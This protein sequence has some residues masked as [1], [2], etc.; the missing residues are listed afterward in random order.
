MLVLGI[1]PGIAITGFGL[2]T[3]NQVGDPEMVDFGVIDSTA[4]STTSSRLVFLYDHLMELLSKYQPTHCAIEKLFFQKN[5]KT[6]MAVGEARGVIQL[7]L[8]QAHLEIMEY[9]P[10]SVK[11]AVTSY[12]S[13]SK[14]QVQE[15]VKILLNLDAIPTPDDAADA[16]AV[17]LCHIG[18]IRLQESLPDEQT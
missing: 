17:A 15:M 4:V 16:L 12:G 8:A 10:N 6:V 2:V 3:V 7:C 11:Q 9:S 13:A 1:D 18:S 14:N 5:L